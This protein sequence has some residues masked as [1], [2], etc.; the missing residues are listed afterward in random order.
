MNSRRTLYLLLTGVALVLVVAAGVVILR[1]PANR[2]ADTVP[3]IPESNENAR[4]EAGDTEET[5]EFTLAGIELADSAKRVL[6]LYG[7]PLSKKTQSEQSVHNPD[8][9][10]YWTTWAYDGF[11]VL[12]MKVMEKGKD[13]TDEY[14]QVFSV[15]VTAGRFGTH[16]GIK[17]GDPAGRIAD[18][19]GK[20]QSAGFSESEDGV[21][22]ETGLNYIRFAVSDGKVT[23]I[24]VGQILN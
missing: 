23:E 17:V 2:P 12:F 16:R 5:M 11:E 19:Y 7:E 1:T 8:Y 22:F 6:D 18:E 15:K 13:P 20:D 4:P 14:G 21:F 24:E 10:S 9:I 3:A